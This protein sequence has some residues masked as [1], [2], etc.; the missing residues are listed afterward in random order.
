MPL[1]PP[2]ASMGFVGY[3]RFLAPGRTVQVRATN[4][5]IQVV[6]NIDKPEVVDGRFDKTVYQLGSMNV[7]GSVTFPSIMEDIGNG[8]DP[9]ATIFKLA[10][11]RNFPGDGKLTPMDIAVAYTN[12][13][14]SFRYKECIINEF[15][16]S[17]QQQGN[18]EVTNSIIGLEREPVAWEPMI[19]SN[20][21]FPRQ[22]RIVTWNDAVV[23]LQN[24]GVGAT[25]AFDI[26]GEYVR[27]FNMTLNNNAERYFT[28]NGKLFPQ[29]IAPRKRDIDGQVV[30]MG[31]LPRLADHAF[32]NQ[33]RCS[34]NSMVTFGYKLTN[35][36]CAG[37]FLVRLPNIVFRIEEMQLMNDLFE[38]TVNWHCLPNYLDLTSAPFLDETGAGF[39]NLPT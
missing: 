6:Q 19:E 17:V 36:N 30:L 28:L 25:P 37:T 8:L 21:Y 3:V 38:T 24:P 31:R 18:V 35:G 16:W 34:E 11:K 12:D 15:Q 20:P 9:T 26:T 23:R 7:E 2:S 5:D 14:A 33:T 4:C 10:T 32:A 1:S 29:D 13:N 27:S 39:A 22:A